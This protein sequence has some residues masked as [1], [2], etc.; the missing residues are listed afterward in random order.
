[1][2]LT[3]D[4]A[5]KVAMKYVKDSKDMGFCDKEF[6]ELIYQDMEQKC[7]IT[8][9]SDSPIT[10]Q[11]VNLI[12][13]VNPTEICN[14]IQNDDLTDWCEALGVAMEETLKAILESEQVN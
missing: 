6:E 5:V 10:V 11:M 2:M 3:I 12:L 9:H 13:Q 14:H 1:M 8:E 4:D 7:W